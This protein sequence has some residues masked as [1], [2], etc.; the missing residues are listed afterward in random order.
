MTI[1]PI[2]IL[3]TVLYSDSLIINTGLKKDKKSITKQNERFPQKMM[4]HE[5]ALLRKSDYGNPF[6]IDHVFPDALAALA[7]F[8]R[9]IPPKPPDCVPRPPQIVRCVPLNQISSK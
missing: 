1:N 2:I 6:P 4:N 3:R 8:I 7:A 9:A 5:P